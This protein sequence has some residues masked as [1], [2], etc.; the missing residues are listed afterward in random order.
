MLIQS[1]YYA[2]FSRWGSAPRVSNASS[3]M[4]WMCRER[5]RKLIFTVISVMKVIFNWIHNFVFFCFF[6]C[7]KCIFQLLYDFDLVGACLFK[8]PW[9]IGIKR[10]LRRWLSR[11][12]TSITRINQLR[13]WVQLLF[14]FQYNVNGSKVVLGILDFM[15]VYV[16]TYVRVC[17]YCVDCR[18]I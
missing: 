12:R 14:F 1:L 13:L 16:W 3:L 15:H 18:Q 9:R 6:F 17:V 7:V 2:N 8:T 10:H 4:I 11:R 5:A